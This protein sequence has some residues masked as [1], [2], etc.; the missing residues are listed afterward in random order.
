MKNKSEATIQ[1][2]ENT[3]CTPWSLCMESMAYRGAAD[4][5]QTHET[6]VTVR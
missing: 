6:P 4:R 1:F 3:L 5:S 2:F